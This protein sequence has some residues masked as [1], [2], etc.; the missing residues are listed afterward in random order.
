MGICTAVTTKCRKAFGNIGA[1]KL[2]LTCV[3]MILTVA[4]SAQVYHNQI[5]ADNIRTV[6]FLTKGLDLS[7]PMLSMGTSDR[8]AFSFDDLDAD[9]KDYYYTVKL[10]NYDWTPS[11]IQAFEYLDGFEHNQINNFNYSYG[12]LQPYTH[13][14]VEL[15]NDDMR[16]TKPGNY[17][18]LVYLDDDPEQ[19]VL[20]HRFYISEQ[21]V[22]I[23]GI[24]QPA[25][26][27]RYRKTHQQVNFTVDHPGYQIDNPFDE[28]KVV[29]L[30]NH[31]SDNAISG[32]RPTFVQDQKLI[33]NYEEGNIFPALKEFRWLD[34][35]SIMVL[36]E[37]I[38]MRERMLGREH[39]WIAPDNIRS[40]DKYF[41]RRDI[42]GNF[43]IDVREMDVPDL[44][45][46]YVHVHITVP[47][48]NPLPT[49]DLYVM[50]GFNYWQKTAE[51]L[52]AYNE[53]RQAYEATLI[54]KQ[55]YYNY[56]I[57]FLEHLEAEMD[58]DLIEGNYFETENDYTVFIYHRP[59][60]QVFDALIG[61]RTFNTIIN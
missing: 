16:L 34:T 12:T 6:R 50:G 58:F 30:Q 59:F 31:R 43:L 18:L 51:N 13:Y 55:G 10:C 26:N 20:T 39:V 2:T 15:P 7:L 53:S 33:Y 56:L 48:S 41:F 32:L 17:V 8:I 9:R 23:K 4:T 45:A 24:A 27:V 5:L 44:N 35:R 22:H 37:R 36:E 11:Q 40:Y 25:V 47:F 28:V 61:V 3:L 1:M 38:K 57:G 14:S 54:L 21:R 46:D 52:M 42:N 49:G 60:G 19:V 29:I